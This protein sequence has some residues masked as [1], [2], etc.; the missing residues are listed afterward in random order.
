[1]SSFDHTETRPRQKKQGEPSTKT[2]LGNP[3]ETPTKKNIFPSWWFFTNAFETYATVKVGNHLPKIFGVNIPN[4]K[5]SCQQ[6]D[7]PQGETCSK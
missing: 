4:K 7:L 2:K 5:K 6:A 1:M 3:A